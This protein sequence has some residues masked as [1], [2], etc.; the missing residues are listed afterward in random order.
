[1]KAMTL[2][3]LTAYGANVE[4]GLARCMGMEDFYLRLVE[5]IK[6]EAGFDTLKGDLEDERFADAFSTAHAL[7]GVLANLALTPMY[8]PVAEL[9]DLLRPKAPV[10][11]ADL[12]N[13]IMEERERFLAL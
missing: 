13:K 3:D 1:M 11:Y 8:E 6:G 5:S 4:E 9:T 7:K 12:L 2:D 10:D